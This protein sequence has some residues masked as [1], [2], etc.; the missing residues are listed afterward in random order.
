MK[1]SLGSGRARFAAV[2]IALAATGALAVGVRL[3]AL[4]GNGAAQLVLGQNDFVHAMPNLGGPSGLYGPEG[5][6][7]DNSVSPNRVY[8][9]DS[10][11]NRV[12]GWRSVSELA[13][14][15]PADLVLGQPDFN[16][17]QADGG[18]MAGD[19]GG[20]GPDSLSFP[21]AAAVD[22]QGNLYVADEDNA[23]VL[24]Y[25]D[26]FSKCAS[27][28]CIGDRAGALPTVV[29]GQ[30]NDF[31]TGTPNN[32]GATAD[33]LD[34]PSSVAVDSKGNLYISDSLNS[35]VL[36]YLANSPSAPFSNTT[37]A[38]PGTPGDTTADVVFG[39]CGTSF[40]TNL[41]SSTNGSSL[42]FPRGITLD[43]SDNL[44]VADNG[45]RV[46]EFFPA[47]SGQP[48]ANAAPASPGTP[49]DTSADVVFGTCNDF[50]GVNC[51]TGNIA[52]EELPDP[53][54][55][56]VDSH[57]NLF[58]ANAEPEFNFTTSVVNNVVEYDQ[59]FTGGTHSGTPG[60]SGDTTADFVIGQGNS[61]SDFTTQVCH[62][63]ANGH[64][65]PN[66]TGLC[67]PFG[68]AI[69]SSDDL[70]VADSF[71]NR[72]LVF[73]ETSNPPDNLTASLALGQEDLVH[74]F[75]NFET[76]W[77][78]RASINFVDDVAVDTTVSPNRIYVADEANNRVLGWKSVAA[79]QNGSPA[80]MVI[81]QP[82]F[83]TGHAN[84]GSAVGD[85]S[86][87]GADSMYGP[88]GVAVDSFGNLYVADSFNNRVLEYTN[89]FGTCASFPCV[90][91]LASIVF[92]QNN[93]FT[94]NKPDLG[95]VS[96]NAYLGP[97]AL[98]FDSRNNLYVSDT[99]N[100]RVLI[101]LAAATNPPFSNSQGAGHGVAGDTTADYA[102]G[103]GAAGNN[104]TART[105]AAGNIDEPAPSSTGLCTPRG[106]ALDSADNLYVADLGNN[107]VLEYNDPLA[108][109][110][111]PNVTANVAF[112]QGAAN[113]FTANT[114]AD[115]RNSNPAPSPT[116]MCA[117]YSVM[118]DASG[119]LYV[120]DSSNN[121]VLE[122]NQPLAN[123]GNPNVTADLVLGQGAD[124][125]DFTANTCYSGNLGLPSPSATGMCGP[126]GIAHDVNGVIYIA[127]ENSRVLAFA[128]PLVS[129]PPTPTPTP[130]VTPTPT[131]TATPTP[132]ATATATA[133][134]TATATAT[135]T[136][137]A[138][139]TATATP[140]T[141]ETPTA[142]PTPISE[143]LTIKPSSLAFGAVTVETTS[144]RKTVTIKNAGSKK[145]GLAVNIEMESASPSVFNVA[146]ECKETLLPG[147]SCKVSVTFNPTD[148]TPQTGSLTIS[149][150][151]TGA[152]QTVALSGTGKAAKKK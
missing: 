106:V 14:G 24:L 51:S 102:I 27:F 146:S 125:A 112:G 103:Q 72:V 115:G 144:K 78:G 46:L 85:V 96:A 35:R 100:N 114:C 84:S 133:T 1:C 138:T 127:D 25:P 104:F 65:P 57:G 82:D 59:P 38:G 118:I 18:T 74:N 126:E 34:G 139:A 101:Y 26:P 60:F 53:V 41:C 151:V 83:L 19:V 67:A 107:R 20:I 21:V 75:V 44:F 111:S 30:L 9:A 124:V 87:V 99:S 80:D 150:N 5:V 71:N 62:D 64:P 29:F 140:T 79:L 95:G 105:C 73:P 15:A 56:A 110:A 89:P 55:V 40:T 42:S 33:A 145:T 141:T 121:R 31:T 10:F 36:E 54:D 94:S 76:N 50:S 116:G 68:V 88:N 136:P 43:S 142:T 47:S 39:W 61:G 66:A 17:S 92:G 137:T 120:S 81:G 4:A 70:L 12:L 63:G 37:G 48:F 148:T 109:L 91:P 119:N 149:D 86:G 7:V 134:P 152:P 2:V 131:A 23:R 132:T 122:F 45:S 16:S 130:T 28:P 108:N 129:S 13:G 58:V 113:N 11:N 143:Q 69:D 32:L 8:V 147:K 6:A 52:A 117:P 90:G 97:S 128:N 3:P 135:A 98:R 22:G 77:N 93:I 123:P 49:G